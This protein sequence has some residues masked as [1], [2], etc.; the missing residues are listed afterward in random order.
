MTLIGENEETQKIVLRM[1]SELLS[2]LEDSREDTGRLQGLDRR[3][4]GT[5]PMSTNLMEKGRKTA[6]S[7]VLNF[8]KSGHIVFRATSALERGEL[9]SKGKGKK[10]I[11]FNGSD[12]TSELILRT[13]VSGNQLSVYGAVADLCRELARNSRGTGKPAANENLESMVIPT[14]FFFYC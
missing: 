9:K 6:E 12:Y 13:I 7:M 3:R 11:H 5:Q 8:A 1:F 10:S 14:F 4:N 2:M